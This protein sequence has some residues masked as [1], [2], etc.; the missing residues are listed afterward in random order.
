MKSSVAA[1]TVLGVFF[2]TAA[3]IPTGLLTLAFAVY[4]LSLLTALLLVG[5]LSAQAGRRPVLWFTNFLLSG[6]EPQGVGPRPFYPS[7]VPA[8]TIA[9]SGLPG[10]TVRACKTALRCRPGRRRR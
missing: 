3:R 4:A 2:A 1:T 6:E 8:A 9:A 7:W 5:S 10:Y